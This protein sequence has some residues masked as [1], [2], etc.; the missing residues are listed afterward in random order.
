MKFKTKMINAAVAAALG[1][2][3]GAAQAV[4][5][6]ADGQG[7]VLIYPYYSVQTKASGVTA[8]PIDTLVSI[9][10][11]DSINGKAVKVR[12]L[13]GKNSV[14]VLDFNLYLSPN[15]MWTAAITRDGSGNAMLRTSDTSCT[16]PEIPLNTA[17]GP[18]NREVSFV[19]FA[20][21]SDNAKDPSM[22]RAREGYLEIIQ[23]ADLRQGVKNGDGLDTWLASKHVAGTP[24]NCA[25]IRASWLGAGYL[26][27]AGVN[28]P[29]GGLSG[30][31][32]IINVPEGTDVSYDAVPMENFTAQALHSNPGDLAPNLGN[33]NPAVSAVL[34]TS[35][36]VVTDW[37]VSAI[38][39]P[40][41]P[42]TA[43][44]M[45]NQLLNEYAVAA[46]PVGL[47]T[48]WVVTMPTKRFHTDQALAANKKPFT[49]SLTTSGACESVTLTAYNRE[50]ATQTTGLQ[51]SPSQSQGNSLC[52]EVNVISMATSST[53]SN[54]L[55]SVTEPVG[56]RKVLGLPFSEG[57]VRVGFL[58]NVVAPVGATTRT[59]IAP[60]PGVNGAVT[61]AVGLTT[62]Y[63]GLPVLGF[64]AQS[65]VN[66]ATLANYGSAYV[67]RY[68]RS[69]TP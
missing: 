49:S 30:A 33:V 7:Q 47:G 68:Y 60:P 24:P 57:W 53:T 3:A 62:T 63:T 69:I 36:L 18:T 12:F 19:N 20:Y 16:A 32:T 10:N 37:T 25:A 22:A 27:N 41:L 31:G 40:V 54:V 34:Q 44:L 5:L 67:H 29:T 52:W 8:L 51:F 65:F 45:R 9:V 21:T 48:D 26:G 46:Q 38:S 15:D 14:E 6:G 28:I 61:T 64:S 35:D 55:G 13:E 1:T 50:E 43:I 4:N 2:L 11:S 17:L 23:M 39:V 42:V 58:Q 66:N 59:V 56:I